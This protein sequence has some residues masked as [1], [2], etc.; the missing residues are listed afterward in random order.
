M[1]LIILTCVLWK[2]GSDADLQRFTGRL[3]YR[4]VALT[5]DKHNLPGAATTQEA[6][7]LLLQLHLQS[8]G[9]T[10][11]VH[12]RIN[13]N[14]AEE[15]SFAEFPH[16]FSF[17]LI[18]CEYRPA[19]GTQMACFC[20]KILCIFPSSGY[21]LVFAY[22]LLNL[23]D[24]FLWVFSSKRR[25]SRLMNSVLKTHSRRLSYSCSCRIT[26]SSCIVLRRRRRKE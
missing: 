3:Q 15:S 2:A 25:A 18:T 4:Y 24:N 8:A 13:S 16:I 14:S 22:V 6:P 21:K 9:H 7:V 17:I 10:C 20:G 19:K 12:G 1:N 23:S 11:T 5:L 26:R